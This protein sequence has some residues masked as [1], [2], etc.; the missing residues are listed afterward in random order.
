MVKVKQLPTRQRIRKALLFVSLLLF[1][2]TLYYFSPVM[3]LE[4]ASQGIINASFIVFGLMFVAALFV[5]RLWCGWAC[6]AGALQEFGSP[7]NDRLALGGK[8]NWIKWAIWIPWI[9]LIAVLVIQAGGYH[10]VDPFHNFEGGVTLTQP[11]EPGGPPW[12]MIYYIIIL[13][14]LGLA[15]AFGRRAGCHFH[16]HRAE[17]S[18]HIQVAGFAHQ[19]GCGQVHRLPALHEGVS[20]EPG[21]PCHGTERLHGKRRVHSVRDVHRRLP[22]TREALFFQHREVD[23]LRLRSGQALVCQTE[24]AVDGRAAQRRLISPQELRPTGNCFGADIVIYTESFVADE[25][26]PRCQPGLEQVEME[27]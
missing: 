1:P 4:S 21:C 9:G 18:E 10:T 16:D 22:A 3:I 17:D 27:P 6:P 26:A 25:E 7:I 24:R 2:V 11:I 12:Y 23:T 5:G 8:F 14:F 13:L 20:D 15:V 19:C